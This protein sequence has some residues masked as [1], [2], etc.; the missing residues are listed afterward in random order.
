MFLKKVSSYFAHNDVTYLPNVVV[1]WLTLLLHIL[2]VVD[3][4]LSLETGY[5]DRFS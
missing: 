4:N 2:E 3:S 5:P 1:G